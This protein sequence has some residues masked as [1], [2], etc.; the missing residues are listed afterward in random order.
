MLIQS[1]SKICC[2]TGSE[3]NYLTSS[4][5]VFVSYHSSSSRWLQVR[6][7]RDIRQAQLS[8]QILLRCALIS[9]K[10]CQICQRSASKHAAMY[11]AAGQ[12]DAFS[13]VSVSVKWVRGSDDT[14]HITYHQIDSR[15][16]AQWN[17]RRC[18]VFQTYTSYVHAGHIWLGM[19]FSMLW[20]KKTWCCFD[21]WSEVYVLLHHM[22]GRTFFKRWNWNFQNKMKGKIPGNDT[23]C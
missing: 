1:R 10:K 11:R 12:M 7:R 19:F 23:L 4:S 16:P 13:C 2:I 9:F 3:G 22:T 14:H 15:L 6:V 5:A 18:L 21:I 17:V 20:G 8:T